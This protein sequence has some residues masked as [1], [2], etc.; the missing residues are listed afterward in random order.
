L[1]LERIGILRSSLGD[2][3]GAEQALRSARA[4]R[5]PIDGR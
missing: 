2:V 1:L 3:E 5:A 4:S